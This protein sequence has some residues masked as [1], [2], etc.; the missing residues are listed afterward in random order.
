MNTKMH[1]QQPFEMDI[2]HKSETKS[3]ISQSMRTENLQPQVKII[4]QGAVKTDDDW[5]E[6]HHVVR[7]IPIDTI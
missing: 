4:I 6:P 2:S 5:Q 1:N 3:V 7:Q